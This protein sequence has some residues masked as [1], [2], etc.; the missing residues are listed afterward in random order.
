MLNPARPN[1][2]AASTIRLHTCCLSACPAMLL[3]LAPA[4]QNHLHLN[5]C[6]QLV[7]LH[8]NLQVHLI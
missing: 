8:L 2:V 7:H 4:C 1:V 3:I 5:L 6:L